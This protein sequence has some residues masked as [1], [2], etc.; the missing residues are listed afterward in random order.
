MSGF[1]VCAALFALAQNSN[2]PV[3]GTWKGE[4]LCTVKPSACHDE[5]VVYEISEGRNGG[6]VWKA[7]KIVNG[8]QENMGELDCTFAANVLTCDMPGKG[9]WSLEVRGDA[10][11]G[12][13]KLSDGTLFRKVS[14][15]RAK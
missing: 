11:N 9:V 4:S 12:T 7:D 8:Q 3:L 13:L 10:M 5:T 1:M 2:A 6:V 14:V 15:H